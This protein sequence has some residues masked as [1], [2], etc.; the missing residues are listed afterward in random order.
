M[1]EFLDRYATKQKCEGDALVGGG[2]I[3]T[4]YQFAS[5]PLDALKGDPTAERK[6]R[7]LIVVL[8]RETRNAQAEANWL[9]SSLPIPL[10]VSSGGQRHESNLP[11]TLSQS[12]VELMYGNHAPYSCE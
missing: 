10:S 2:Q 12:V 7:S 3:K 9:S 4:S 8:Q 6:L 5:S 11:F 1:F